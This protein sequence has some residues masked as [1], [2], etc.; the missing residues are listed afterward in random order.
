MVLF[1]VF[2]TLVVKGVTT[3]LTYYTAGIVAGYWSILVTFG[4]ILLCD[5]L[6]PHATPFTTNYTQRAFVWATK[7]LFSLATESE[8]ES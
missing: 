6:A 1:C 5:R 8:S 7:G 4:L 2:T 3:L